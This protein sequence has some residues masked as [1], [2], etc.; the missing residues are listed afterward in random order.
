[1]TSEE[2]MAG[3]KY[4]KQLIFSFL[5]MVLETVPEDIISRYPGDL[6]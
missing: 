1:M 5:P 3:K 4:M 2:I 6:S